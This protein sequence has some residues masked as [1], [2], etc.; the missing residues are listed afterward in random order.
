MV[1]LRHNAERNKWKQQRTNFHPNHY[2]SY[3]PYEEKLMMDDYLSED[4]TSPSANSPVSSSSSQTDDHDTSPCLPLEKDPKPALKQRPNTASL[5][6]N[7]PSAK[8]DLIVEDIEETENIADSTSHLAGLVNDEVS[9]KMISR[10][11]SKPSSLP[12]TDV[13][14]T[15]AANSRDPVYKPKPS[16][17]SP[18]VTVISPEKSHD[19]KSEVTVTS[20]DVES[21]DEESHDVKSEVTVTAPDEESH[22]TKRDA[23]P[24]SLP[25]HTSGNKQLSSKEKL[26]NNSFPNQE[27]CPPVK[28]STVHVPKHAFSSSPYYA[29][30]AKTSVDNKP[31][32]HVRKLMFD[33]GPVSSKTSKIYS[34]SNSI[35]PGKHG[36]LY[37]SSSSV[38]RINS[39]LPCKICGADLQAR[40]FQYDIPSQNKT[41]SREE[42][43]RNGPSFDEYESNSTLQKLRLA[44]LE[45]KKK[46]E[47]IR[48]RQAELA[49]RKKSCPTSSLRSVVYTDKSA[50]SRTKSG[51]VSNTKPVGD[52][53]ELSLSTMS[54]SSCSVA[55]EIL[56]KAK[57][58]RDSFW[59]GSMTHK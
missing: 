1:E 36:I 52:V 54:I 19:M 43:F 17:S 44:Q 38:P 48:A 45:S 24:S 18:H 40:H 35:P 12:V 9:R 56:E 22:D 13:E 21:P 3:D 58:R 2:V 11:K 15:C 49:K 5:H 30:C 4:V 42:D 53:D 57:K 41:L 32:N 23:P 37:N 31:P 46:L 51:E 27:T 34:L 7:I 47:S 8:D 26:L 6:L 20:P 29:Y 25:D 28:G 16:L 55:S 14:C 39:T 33:G 59:T 50:S 10:G